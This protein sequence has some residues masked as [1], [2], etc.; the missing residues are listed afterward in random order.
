MHQ[1]AGEEAMAKTQ[2]K[3]QKDDVQG[4][5][6]GQLEEAKERL[7]Q[8][9]DEA[10][11][12]VKN[13][14]ARGQKSREEI[15]GLLAKLNSAEL[16]PTV[17]ELS[18][19]ATIATAEVRKKLDGLQTRVIEATGVASQSQVKAIGKEI[20][21]LSKKVDGLVGKKPKGEVRA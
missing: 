14:V 3:T 2:V 21:R 17:R 5:L 1:T 18:R 20:A 15:E 12:V 13:L 7:T 11:K 16:A 4:F 9:E 6:K 19:R 8:L 10:Q